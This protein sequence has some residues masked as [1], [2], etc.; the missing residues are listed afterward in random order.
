MRT[1]SLRFKYLSVLLWLLLILLASSTHA[2]EYLVSVQHYSVPEGLSDRYVKSAK[3]DR[4]GFIWAASSDGISRFDGFEFR[5]YKMKKADKPQSTVIEKICADRYGQLWLIHS[6]QPT[7]NDAQTG[8]YPIN[9]FLPSTGRTMPL[10]AA[11]QSPFTSTEVREIQ[12]A[13]SGNIYFLLSSGMLYIN[14]GSKFKNLIQTGAAKNAIMAVSNEE[15]IGVLNGDSLLQLDSLGKVLYRT[16]LPVAGDFIRAA[17]GQFLVGKYSSDGRS[18]LWSIRAG[19]TARPFHFTDSEGRSVNIGWDSNFGCP[20]YPDR[21]GRW[22][23]FSKQRLLLFDPDGNFLY[24]FMGDLK[25]LEIEP[26]K[27]SSISF[28][29]HNTAWIGSGIG[30]TSISIKKNLFTNYLAHTGL[31]DSRGIVQDEK[32]HLYLVQQGKVWADAASGTATPLNLSAWLAAS[33][34]QHD[35]LWFGDYAYKVHCY[36][37]LSGSKQTFYPPDAP[38]KDIGNATRAIFSDPGSGRIWIG[39]EKEGLAFID[40]G[41]TVI[42]P[43]TGYNKFQDLRQG[44][45]NCFVEGESGIWLGTNTGVYLLD[46]QNGI[47]AEYSQRTGDLPQAEIFHIH[48]DQQGIFWLASPGNGLIRWDRKKRTYRQFTQKDGL[49]NDILYA[50]YEDDFEHLWL[51]SNNG[52]MQFD[53]H[54]HQVN[55]YLPRDGIPHEEFNFSSHYQADDGRLFFGGLKGITAFYPKTL[56]RENVNRSLHLGISQYL[57]LDGATG[58]FVDK[59]PGL[60]KTNSIRLAPQNKSFILKIL[61]PDYQSPKDNRFAYRI[62]GLHENW[63]YQTS[64]TLQIN[65]LPYGSFTLHIKAQGAN[66]RWATRELKLPLVVLRPFYLRWWFLTSCIG[67][68]AFF[69]WWR[70]RIL[71]QA[72][73]RLEAEVKKRTHQI[74]LDKQLIEKQALELRQLDELKSRFFAN[75]AH[76]FRTPLTLILGP[77]KKML[78]EPGLENRFFSALKLIQRNAQGLLRMAEDILDMDKLEAHRLEIKEET[79]SFYP[80]IRRLVSTFE[81]HAQASG[82]ELQFD[83]NAEQYLQLKLD[84]HKFERIVFNLLSNALKFTN[85]N[86]QVAV[87]VSDTAGSIRISVTDTGRGIHPDDLP[88]VFDRFFQAQG[89]G[90]QAEGGAGIGLAL[91]SEYADLMNGKLRVES[92]LNEGS[93]FIF[94]FPKKEVFGKTPDLEPDSEIESNEPLTTIRPTQAPDKQQRP[95]ILV[96][97][98]NSD[99]RGFLQEVL[100]PHYEVRTAENG[101]RALELLKNLA[102]ASD[103]IQVPELIITDL[104]M[105]EMDGY[106]LLEALKTD[107]RWQAVPVIVLTARA[108]LSDR[109][110]ALRIG[111]DDYL[112]KP[113]DTEELLARASNLINNYRKRLEWLS[114]QA[115]EAK[116]QT[117]ATAAFPKLDQLLQ[118]QEI[119]SADLVW[120]EAVEKI[121]FEQ[122]G[123]SEFT[124]EQLA[125]EL[126]LSSRQLRRKL[127]QLTGMAPTDYL[128]EIRLQKARHLLENKARAT[129]AEV[130]Y[131]VGLSDLKHFAKIFRQ[132]FGKNPSDVLG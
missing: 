92:R 4:Q 53:K 82:I 91:A 129:V 103:Q 45:I 64:N 62:E 102:A 101:A 98:D 108:S 67:L 6:R 96:V 57:E 124:A 84:V 104:M 122:I 41:N 121:A 99:M 1:F 71:Q 126:A 33:R 25:A 27:P 81:S 78:K 56:Y 97:E 20:V 60:L 131:A 38:G 119:V 8:H 107:A 120:L 89:Q 115:P 93:S 31:T 132:R 40:P 5:Q 24:D 105:P 80:L 95:T 3:Q 12:S 23:V 48:I 94:E 49:S 123:P 50:V 76:E 36:D 111:I 11:F 13:S 14:D 59:T 35:R 39:T 32:G 55:T 113:F 65:A 54:S 47:V 69:I 29:S 58:A 44:R 37:P 34:D 42:L 74:E 15:I 100:S 46:P 21:E 90:K 77:L 112:A 109:L 88:H 51:P 9:L 87:E 110:T 30:L 63:I 117:G 86:G 66:G 83:Y 75:M 7:P 26:L 10:E 52:L 106:S 68:L 16:A 72:T 17:K 130:C 73:I 22:W 118:S 127:Q 28:D 2:Q 114:K 85:R 43:F 61:F 128:R 116:G 125:E 70:I 79:T 19:Q 18:S